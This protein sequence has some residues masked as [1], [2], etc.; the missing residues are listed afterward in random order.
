MKKL[1][2]ISQPLH[3]DLPVWP[4]DTAFRRDDNWVISE[5]SPVKVSRLTLSTHSGA[6]AD[7]PEHYDRTGQD[8]ASVSLEPYLG[9][10][11]LVTA[12]TGGSDVAPGDL[13]WALIGDHRRVL[14]RTYEN[15][16][17]DQWDSAFR[18]INAAT[19]D[20]LAAAGCTL[21]GTD[22][23]S[24]DPETS[25]TLDAHHA[26]NRHDMRILEG[27]VF[28]GVPDGRYELIA[29]PLPI[30]NADASPIRAILR[31]L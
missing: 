19:I 23:A 9:E 12:D 31:E 16:P 5:D 17:H 20:K 28:D 3:A 10:C 25:R 15:F 1:W 18:A 21:I 29:L 27:L 2:D 14:V 4:G 11:V 13:D 6:H 24:L 26:V 7:A 30:V 22:A 8:I